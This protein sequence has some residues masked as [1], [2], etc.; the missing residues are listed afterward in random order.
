MKYHQGNIKKLQPIGQAGDGLTFKWDKYNQKL[1]TSKWKPIFDKVK[2]Y[3]KTSQ[4]KGQ[5]EPEPANA[6]NYVVGVENFDN[7]R[8]VL[9]PDNINLNYINLVLTK[10]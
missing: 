2:I 6:V 10:S 5:L 3:K 9:P 4:A 1:C 8:R 7:V